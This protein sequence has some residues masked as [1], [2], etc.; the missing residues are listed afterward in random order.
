MATKAKRYKYKRICPGS[1][2]E[3]KTGKPGQKIECFECG[4]RVTLTV[5]K[6]IRKHRIGEW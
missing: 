5:D 2:I 4:K 6:K 3:V 1:G